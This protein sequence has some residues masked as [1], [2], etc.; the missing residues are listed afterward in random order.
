LI[1][2]SGELII[3]LLLRRRSLPLDEVEGHLGHYR[4]GLLPESGIELMP[5]LG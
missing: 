4:D 2:W 5:H 1:E 3:Y